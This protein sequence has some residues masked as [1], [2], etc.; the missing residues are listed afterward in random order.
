MLARGSAVEEWQLCADTKPGH[1]QTV[2]E[3]IL[4]LG[5]ARL[6]VVRA[7]N[8]KAVPNQCSCLPAMGA[9]LGLVLLFTELQELRCWS[10]SCLMAPAVPHLAVCERLCLCLVWK[11][12][13]GGWLW[14]L[15]HRNVPT[16]AGDRCVDAL[17]LVCSHRR[18]SHRI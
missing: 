5:G 2:Q 10:R 12:E 13:G 7:V 11:L 15:V 14:L 16:T 8:A 17:P 3:R 6:L 18:L 1:F 4:A 9:V